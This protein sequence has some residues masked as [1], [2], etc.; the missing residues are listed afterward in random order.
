MLRLRRSAATLLLAWIVL[1][2][3]TAIGPVSGEEA[4]GPAAPHCDHGAAPAPVDQAPRA[5]S[6]P[7]PCQWPLP[8]LC[9][10]QVA[11]A[12]AGGDAVIP[13]PMLWMSWGSALLLAPEEPPAP[14]P[15]ALPA[16]AAPSLQR[17][18]VLQV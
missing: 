11:A 10:Q 9:C 18:V 3:V 4:P 8:L 5:P 14:V 7:A 6:A 12:D 15:A 2:T 13:P 16:L 17:S 1:G